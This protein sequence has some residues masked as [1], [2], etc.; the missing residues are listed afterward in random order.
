M[1]SSFLKEDI[2]HIWDACDWKKLLYLNVHMTAWENNERKKIIS[3]QYL[4]VGAG[5]FFFSE[6]LEEHKKEPIIKRKACLLFLS[7]NNTLL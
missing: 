5:M 1:F 7:R 6:I 2:N 3:K 4:R